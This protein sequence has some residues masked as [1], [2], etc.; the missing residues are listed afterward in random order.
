[1]LGRLDEAT[2]YSSTNPLHMLL[3]CFFS[4]NHSLL[5]ECHFRVASCCYSFTTQ[6]LPSFSKPDSYNK[7]SLPTAGRAVGRTE[8]TT[9]QKKVWK[10]HYTHSIGKRQQETQ[11]VFLDSVITRVIESVTCGLSLDNNV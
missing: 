5:S 7:R 10:M 11:A 8:F 2:P 3:A 6:L 9:M 4:V 1:M